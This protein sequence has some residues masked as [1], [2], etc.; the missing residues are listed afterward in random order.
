VFAV[1]GKKINMIWKNCC[2]A[3][4]SVKFWGCFGLLTC[5]ASSLEGMC[6]ESRGH[7]GASARL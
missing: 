1:Q 3:L 2:V 5:A 4:T 6:P 7:T